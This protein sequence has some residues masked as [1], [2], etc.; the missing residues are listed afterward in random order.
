MV[1][2]VTGA[3]PLA[4][5]LP[6]LESLLLGALKTHECGD[7]H[8]P[9]VALLDGIGVHKKIKIKR[10][11]VF[12]RLS[13]MHFI[14]LLTTDSSGIRTPS[15]LNE[16]AE[17]EEEACNRSQEYLSLLTLRHRC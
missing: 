7:A 8:Q 3:R 6:H 10:A 1:G 17:G 15:V 5:G 16:H 14:T 12:T 11:L 4:A 9:Q 2:V 13:R